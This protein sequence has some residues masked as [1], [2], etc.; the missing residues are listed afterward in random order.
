MARIQAFSHDYG[1]RNDERL[2]N[3]RMHHGM[4]GIG[5]YWC[6]AEMLYEQGGMMRVASIDAIAFDLN[7]D[8][9]IIRSIIID[10]DLFTNDG[11]MFW[12]P[13]GYARLMH[14]QRV[15]AVRSI[16]GRKGGAPVGNR[17]A[18]QDKEQDEQ[19]KPPEKP[20][21][22]VPSPDEPKRKYFKKPSVYEVEQE[23]QAKGYHFDATAFVAFYES[24]DWM[25]GKNK[26]KN[27]KMA[28]VTWEKRHGNERPKPQQPKTNVN[29]IWK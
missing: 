2:L 17:N 18:K 19:T 16:T 5:I 14:Q 9:D 3:V 11:E 29:D 4:A 28:M 12:S 23:I 1:A 10:F 6:I 15:S 24:K 25:I 7:T 21:A 22:P 13:S 8:V 26:M 20:V 27:W